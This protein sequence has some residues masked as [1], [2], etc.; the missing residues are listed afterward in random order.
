MT[1]VNGGKGIGTGF[2][3]EGLCHDPLMVI[4]YVKNK[5]KNKSNENVPIEPYYEGFK[6]TICKEY[7]KDATRYI[8][9]GAYEIIGHDQVIIKELPIGKWTEDYKAELETLMEDKGKNGKK[10][11]P[12]VKNYTDNCTD[13]TVEFRVKFHTGVLPDLVG[14]QKGTSNVNYFEKVMKLTTSKTPN[15]W[16]FNEKQ[17]LRK[18][19]NVQ[20]IID[21][22]YPIRYKG[23]VDRKEYQIKNLERQLVLLSNKARFIKEQC[24]DVI[25]LRKK[26]KDVVIQLLKDRNYNILDGD[27][28]YKYLREMR[29]SMV[30]EENYNKLMTEKENKAKE[31]EVLK[32]TTIEQIWLKELNELEK[33]IAKYRNDRKVRQFGLGAKIKKK[34]TGKKGKKSK[35]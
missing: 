17:K 31:L 13:T 1:L 32:N 33:A 21:T 35:K 24:D 5:L 20:E 12:I 30:E 25:D 22:Y 3:Y 6:G 10:K 4:E 14:S 19:A 11:K 23:Y 34:T 8:F 27:E 18:F 26:K 16:M 28:E 2:A 15:L 29:L 7:V 9:K